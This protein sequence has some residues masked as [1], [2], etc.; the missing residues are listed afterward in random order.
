MQLELPLPLLPDLVGGHVQRVSVN[1]LPAHEPV[2]DLDRFQ[3]KPRANLDQL[4]M[5][6]LLLS[7]LIVHLI[8]PEGDE[9]AFAQEERVDMVVES[10]RFGVVLRGREG[11]GEH[12][13]DQ[14]PFGLVGLVESAIKRDYGAGALQAV[15][16]HLDI[17]RAVD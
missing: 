14:L 6:E 8:M 12:F 9:V 3:G 4:K 15:A 1:R 10:L 5:L 16:L 17:R 11:L 7:L 2:K 13:F